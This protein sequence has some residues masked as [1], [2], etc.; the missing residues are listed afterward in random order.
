MRRGADAWTQ[1]QAV[2]GGCGACACVAMPLEKALEYLPL[3]RKA[4]EAMEGT[5]HPGDTVK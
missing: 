5:F 1:R 2:R 3:L 4:A